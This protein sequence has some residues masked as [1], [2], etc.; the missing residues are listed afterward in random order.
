MPFIRVRA[1]K[2]FKISDNELKEGELFYLPPRE[3]RRL[4]GEGKVEMI[5]S[6]YPEKLEPK[7]LSEEPPGWTSKK[8]C[9]NCPDKQKEATEDAILQDGL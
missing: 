9:K 1:L 7:D 8:P 5:L 3:A 4:Q 2:K 6:R